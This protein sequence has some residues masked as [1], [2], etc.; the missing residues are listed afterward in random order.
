MF[1]CKAAEAVPDP[2]AK[3]VRIFSAGAATCDAGVFEIRVG[4][5]DPV[6]GLLGV[7]IELGTSYLVCVYIYMRVCI[8]YAMSVKGGLQTCGGILW[9]TFWWL[10][11]SKGRPWKEDLR[12]WDC[13]GASS[14]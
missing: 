8:L 7:T 4:V 5:L 14:P 12:E 10:G 13:W 3:L 1:A 11:L 6:W 2:L 9:Q